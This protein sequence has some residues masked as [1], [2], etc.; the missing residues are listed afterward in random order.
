MSRKPLDPGGVEPIVDTTSPALDSVPTI[1][2]A[3]H[4][5]LPGEL[6]LRDGTPAFV[7]PLLPTDAETLR[8]G[9]RR[10]SPD[11]RRRRFLTSLTALNDAMIRYLVADVDGMSHIA[12]VLV[13]LPAGGTERPAGVARLVLDPTDP[14]TADIAIT[15]ADEWQGRGVGSALATELLARRPATVR[16]LKTAVAADNDASLALLAK[17][18]RVSRTPPRSG[19]VD[20]T[21]ELD[22]A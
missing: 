8:D 3:D 11:S 13:A 1:P 10:L 14:I 16:R 4:G 20:V 15:V 7:W 17:L 19:V 22:A 9:F 12:L 18:G 5:P 2:P 6:V 21:V